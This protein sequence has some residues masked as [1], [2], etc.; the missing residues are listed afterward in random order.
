[1]KQS[2]YPSQLQQMKV[3]ITDFVN[4]E[5]T[6][7]YNILVINQNT[8]SQLKIK[9]RYS[10]LSELNES[11]Q[12]FLKKYKSLRVQLPSFPAKKWW[13]VQ[14]DSFINH[15]KSQL[16]Q[17]FQELL[18]QE[19]SLLIDPLTDFLGYVDI[20]NSKSP[21]SLDEKL[22]LLRKKHNEHTQ[23]QKNSSNS[24]NTIRAHY[25]QSETQEKCSQDNEISFPLSFCE[26][27]LGAT[28][29]QHINIGSFSEE[30][31]SIKRKSIDQSDFDNSSIM[32]L[33]PSP[34][35]M[36]GSF[37]IY[38]QSNERGEESLLR[39][40][41]EAQRNNYQNLNK[42]SQNELDQS[43]TNYQNVIQQ[44]MNCINRNKTV[45]PNVYI[46][47]L[48]E[49]KA[50]QRKFKR[51]VEQIIESSEMS[52]GIEQ[53][54]FCDSDEEEFLDESGQQKKQDSC[55]KRQSQ[56]QSQQQQLLSGSRSQC[57]CYNSGSDSESS[58]YSDSDGDDESYS[59]QS[60]LQQKSY[61]KS[62]QRNS[63]K[64]IIPIMQRSTD[65]DC[66]YNKRNKPKSRQSSG[67]KTNHKT[68]NILK[69]L[70]SSQS[71]RMDQSANQGD[72]ED[73]DAQQQTLNDSTK[74]IYKNEED[75]NDNDHDHEQQ[76]QQNSHNSQILRD[77]SYNSAS[78]RSPTVCIHKN[79]NDNKQFHI[80]F[81][82]NLIE[83]NQ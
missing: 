76:E 67:K 72:D 29:N 34:P 39:S 61:T 8:S 23:N 38:R 17:Y 50:T 22:E 18:Q 14:D 26:I 75:C 73:D 44:A 41:I 55:K 59:N 83:L 74:T 2:Q 6:V 79:I 69:Y 30:I 78:R 53:N 43:D 25:E 57:K 10:Q 80:Q 37:P 48:E 46:Y 42:D 52:S 54:L 31:R 40:Q 12:K 51:E 64:N 21:K 35:N 33:F 71:L 49:Y 36:R 9:A 4:E 15:R 13:V 11:I 19:D 45:Q 7:F 62:F 66:A 58:S 60:K 24:S 47:N 20:G 5:G 77:L 3:Q 56:L 68:D 1:M 81:I 70:N 63:I 28:K 65:D 27:S 16:E 82:Q 32:L